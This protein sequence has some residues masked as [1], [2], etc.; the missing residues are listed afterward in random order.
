MN[1]ILEVKNIGKKYQ[2]KEGEVQA[3]IKPAMIWVL[4]FRMS[5]L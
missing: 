5:I 4:R 2:N 1:E 3:S